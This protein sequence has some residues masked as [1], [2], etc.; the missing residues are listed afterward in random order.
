[1][2][3][4][5]KKLLE[6]AARAAGYKYSPMGGYIV[7]DGIPMNWNPLI[8]GG[9]ALRL[10]THLLINVEYLKP[11]GR[12]NLS[13]VSAF[14]SGRGDCLSVQQISNDPDAATRRAI[15]C[16]AAAMG[17]SLPATSSASSS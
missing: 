5:D 7:M 6:L 1:M 11:L 3:V 4:S 10:S 9:D 17:Q 16:A 12:R 13:E 14:P 2:E 15:V 8:D